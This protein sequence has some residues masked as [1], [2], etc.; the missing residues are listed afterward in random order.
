MFWGVLLEE[1]LEMFYVRLNV[2]DLPNG[3][4]RG[5]VIHQLVAQLGVKDDPST[6]DNTSE[7]LNPGE[8]VTILPIPPP[9]EM[10]P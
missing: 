10:S 4:T 6:G 9:S 5:T 1:L 2:D 3:R 7:M 8:L